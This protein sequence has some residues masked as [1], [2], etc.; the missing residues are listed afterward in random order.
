MGGGA[1]FSV[2]ESIRHS[3]A[4]DSHLRLNAPLANTAGPTRIMLPIKSRK[5]GR[6]P[7]QTRTP[8]GIASLLAGGMLALPAAAQVVTPD[9]SADDAGTL[10]R[11][12][13]EAARL[14]YSNDSL[15]SPKFTQ[16]LVDTTRTVTVIG[17]ELFNEQG[18]TTLTAQG[19]L[20]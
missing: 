15:S 10:D 1:T 16:P 4:N 9:G 13:V 3:F 14:K 18:A 20:A 12:V 8:L 17:S 6:T 11:V 2:V 5:H 19:S 7:F